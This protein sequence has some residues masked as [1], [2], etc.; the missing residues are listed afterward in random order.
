MHHLPVER[1]LINPIEWALPPPSPN[2]PSP[3]PHITPLCSIA[4][5]SQYHYNNTEYMFGSILSL[6]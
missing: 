3:L 1:Y 2:L 5:S 6:V 4:Y